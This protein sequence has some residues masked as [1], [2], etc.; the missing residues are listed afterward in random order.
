MNKL[1]SQMHNINKTGVSF[2]QNNLRHICYRLFYIDYVTQ[3]FYL[4]RFKNS[5]GHKKIENYLE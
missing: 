5:M 4:C 1:I 2:T 3:S